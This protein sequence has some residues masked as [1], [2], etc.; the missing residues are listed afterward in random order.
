M[1]SLSSDLDLWHAAKEM[2]LP[3]PRP[4]SYRDASGAIQISPLQGL[5]YEEFLSLTAMDSYREL[6]SWRDLPKI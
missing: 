3:L 4:D 2:F 6:H 1:K 5:E